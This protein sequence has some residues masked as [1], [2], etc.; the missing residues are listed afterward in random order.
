MNEMMNTQAT[1]SIAPFAS[2]DA[3]AGAQRIAM[4]LAHSTIVPDAFR[5]KRWEG[6]GGQDAD[7]AVANC[8]IALQLASRMQADIFMIMQNLYIIHGRPAFS[9][10]FVIAA[11]NAS[12]RFSPLQF[13]PFIKDGV[14]VG[15]QAVAKSKETGDVLTGPIVTM[16]MAQKEGWASKNGSKWR[17]M[18]D[19][20]LRYRAA[21]FFG[22]LYAPDVMMGMQTQEEVEDSGIQAKPVTP[23]KPAPVEKAEK[24]E[25]EAPSALADL[26]ALINAPE[27]E[28]KEAEVIEEKEP[29]AKAKEQEP[30]AGE[31]AEDPELELKNMEA[32][33]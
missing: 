1:G 6:D 28:V 4:A 3:F 16:E 33:K 19:V 12:G 27:K 24:V 8:L 13:K 17:T 21:S 32:N 11:I 7:T 26:N 14:V 2:F 9:A 5:A 18:P 10:Q 30:P 22:R 25:E 29:S 23:E 20:M 31:A 15:C